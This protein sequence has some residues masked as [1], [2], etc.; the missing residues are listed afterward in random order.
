[1]WSVECKVWSGKRGVGSESVECRARNATRNATL[2]D[3]RDLQ[4]AA[5]AT[6]TATHLVKTKQKQ[7]DVRH[8]V[9]QI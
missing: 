3:D 6:K 7:T 8:V 1:V 4:N 2:N 9:K 5:P